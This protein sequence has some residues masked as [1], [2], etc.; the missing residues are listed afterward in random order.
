MSRCWFVIF[1][2]NYFTLYSGMLMAIYDINYKNIVNIDEDPDFPEQL[3]SK[4]KAWLDNKRYLFKQGRHGTG[5]DWAE[6]VA[7]AICDLLGI[8]HAKYCLAVD[9]DGNPGVL[10]KSIV[11]D[12]GRLVHGNEL[13]KKYNVDYDDTRRFK[14]KEHTLRRVFAL[15]F[16]LS[17]TYNLCCPITS[18]Y[19]GHP[20]SFFTS[21]LMLDALIGNQDR[22]HENWAFILHQD[23]LYLAET[24][25]H[26]SSLGR[27]DSDEKKIK[28]LEGK[29]KRLTIK[30][31]CAR[32]KTPFYSHVEPVR[33]LLTLEAYKFAKDNSHV[34]FCCDFS[35][36]TRESISKIFDELPKNA[37]N[38]PNDI[39]SEFAI[40]MILENKRR[41]LEIDNI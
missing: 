2:N 4:E 16:T 21:Y 13:L 23:K 33:Q 1:C 34:N 37:N 11:P 15:F 8:P 29:D 38:I 17:N 30:E 22:H 32:A 26:A 39:S 7:S 12:G 14:L 18:R 28:I 35:K 40:S 10:T 36:I 6:V 5:E 19:D 41:V 3:G 31:Y 9:K 27:N 25:D 20:V 24:F